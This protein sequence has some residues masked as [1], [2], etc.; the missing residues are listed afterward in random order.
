MIYRSFLELAREEDALCREIQERINMI[1]AGAE[2]RKDGMVGKLGEAA[3][4][5]VGGEVAKL[6]PGLH[7]VRGEMGAHQMMLDAIAERALRERLEQPGVDAD[8]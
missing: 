4:E 3:L 8:A 5:R 6:L 2:A 7:R 1:H